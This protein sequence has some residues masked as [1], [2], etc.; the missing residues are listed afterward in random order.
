M[1]RL[2]QQEK[3]KREKIP[4]PAGLLQLEVD[5]HDVRSRSPQTSGQR[6]DLQD[7]LCCRED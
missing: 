4:H 1:R 6:V 5:I 7:A 2:N 3:L